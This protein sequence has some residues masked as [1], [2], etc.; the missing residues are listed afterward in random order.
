MPQLNPLVLASCAFLGWSSAALGDTYQRRVQLDCASAAPWCIATFA[1]VPTGQKLSIEFV[2]CYVTSSQ[3]MWL[4]I[5]MIGASPAREGNTQ[6]RHQLLAQRMGGL[7]SSWA[8]SQPIQVNIPT[9]K[10]PEVN[11]VTIA[12]ANKS[13]ECSISGE[14]NPKP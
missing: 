13:G 12:G 6:F 3:D 10:S 4:G 11:F 7:N 8:I 1:P 2:S 9:G 14:I 5:A